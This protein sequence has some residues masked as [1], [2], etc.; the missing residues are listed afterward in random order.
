MGTFSPRARVEVELIAFLGTGDEFAKKN[1]L[2][3]AQTQNGLGSLQIWLD[4]GDQDP[5]ISQT[6]TLHQTLQD[7]DIQHYWNP[8]PGGHDWRYWE[9]HVL[10]YVRF[11]GHA[12][13]PQ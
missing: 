13:S 6:T 10:D 11:Y 8:Y 1:P 9:D 7:R 4:A 2:A 5:W 3:L 12:L